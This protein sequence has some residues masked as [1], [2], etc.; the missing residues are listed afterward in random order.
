MVLF[1]KSLYSINDP[2]NS[3]YKTIN[4]ANLHKL[5]AQK[6]MVSLFL[7]PYLVGIFQQSWGE[8]ETPRIK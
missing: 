7:L 4:R 3:M 1:K 2:I 8:K 5:G 6:Q